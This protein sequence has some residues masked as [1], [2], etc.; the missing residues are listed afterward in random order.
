MTSVLDG[1]EALLP[2]YES[3]YVDLHRNP[4]LS[5]AEHRT[6][7]IAARALRDA[8]FE[9]T[10]GVGRT[11][12][13]G[14]LRNGTGPTV[15]LRA[16][17]DALPVRERTGLDYASAATATNDEGDVVPVTHACGHDMH[18]TWML[19]AARLLAAGRS[20]WSGTLQVVLQPGEEAGGGAE[21][22]IE[23]G[24]FER[25][26]CPDIAFGQ[27]V[28]PMS[29]G[30]VFTRP[31]LVMAATDAFRVRMFGRGGHGS[32]PEATTDPVVLASSTVLRLQTIVSREVAP[33][34]S[35]VVTVGSLQAGTTHNV[36]PSE[37]ELTVN[38]RSFDPEVRER[39]V[40]AT[41]RIVHAE[42]QAAGAPKPPEITPI[43]SFPSNVNDESATE[44]V[45]E[46]FRA[47]FG[48]DRVRSGPLVA[49]SEDFGTFGTAA[50]APA[51]FWFVGGMDPERV[52]AARAA[53]TVDRDIPSNH[54]PLFAPVL[55]P[56]LRTG[57]ETLVT[58]A[59][60]ELW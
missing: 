37:A 58:A 55:Y 15:L 48:P 38:I 6:A 28:G 14:L 21:G 18:V 13:V 39:V 22:M 11:G 3:L 54:S 50:E 9:V 17:M 29:A 57:V 7:G 46:R 1:L 40:A 4:E 60:G 24:L 2:E 36:I 26:G 34:E 44:R 43:T 16:D 20:E 42:A 19:G 27:H 33:T 25:F 23:D 59:L 52:A 45:S 10:T 30:E 47:H 51:V 5:F 31:G 12:V 49:G 8:G 53:D 56:T 32:R 41:H 35:A